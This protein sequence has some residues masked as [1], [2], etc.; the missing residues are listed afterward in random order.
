MFVYDVHHRETNKEPC[1]IFSTGHGGDNHSEYDNTHDS[2]NGD[3]EDHRDILVPKD[4]IYK[5]HQLF[6]TEKYHRTFFVWATD[7]MSLSAIIDTFNSTALICPQKVDGGVFHL[8]TRYVSDSHQISPNMHEN[9]LPLIMS[10][11][12]NEKHA[13]SVSYSFLPSRDTSR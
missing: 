6:P 8:Q 1:P 11:S 10:K 4:K 9:F 5:R 7:A 13:I 3:Q 12:N 2:P